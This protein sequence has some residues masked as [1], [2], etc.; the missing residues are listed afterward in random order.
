M[1]YQV[2]RFPG[3]A[4]FT[5][6]QALIFVVPAKFLCTAP[7]TGPQE[8]LVIQIEEFDFPAVSPTTLLQAADV[9]ENKTTRIQPCQEIQQVGYDFYSVQI[10]FKGLRK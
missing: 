3:A 6:C 2:P 8:P 5:L 1:P 9:T 10:H 7:G 4:P